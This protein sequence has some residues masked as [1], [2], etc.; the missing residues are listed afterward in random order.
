[1]LCLAKT[2]SKTSTFYWK[3]KMG[4]A[5]CIS[6]LH[7]SHLPLSVRSPASSSSHPRDISKP[8]YYAFSCFTP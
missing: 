6:S 8:T 7:I 1:M 3:K 2:L 5:T 4:D